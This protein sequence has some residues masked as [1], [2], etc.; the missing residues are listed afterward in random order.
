M[1]RFQELYPGKDNFCRVFELPDIYPSEYLFGGGTPVPFLMVDWFQPWPEHFGNQP[2]N[3]DDCAEPLI[4]FLKQKRY[5]KAGRQY[6]V[7]TTFGE[8]LLF[9][10]QE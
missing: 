7:V 2:K 10:G 6:I 4:E 3:W 1:S 5:V 8:T 9:E